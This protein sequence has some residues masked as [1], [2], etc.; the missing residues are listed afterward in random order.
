VGP[1]CTRVDV[2]ACHFHQLRHL[3]ASHMAMAGA[4]LLS[5]G[6]ILGHRNSS[7]TEGCSHLSPAHLV[8]ESE[9]LRFEAPAGEVVAMV[10]NGE[11]PTR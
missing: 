2:P 8:Q 9:R 3:F 5:I 11:R 10:G 6:R 7:T 1:S 4:S